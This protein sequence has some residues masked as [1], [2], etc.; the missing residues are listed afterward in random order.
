[1]PLVAVKSSVLSSQLSPLVDVAVLLVPVIAA[2]LFRSERQRGIPLREYDFPA[3]RAIQLPSSRSAAD[4]DSAHRSMRT[5][6]TTNTR[7]SLDTQQQCKAVA[8]PLCLC[9]WQ[10]ELH[11]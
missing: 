2:S 6:S 7:Q 8:Q 1:M 3:A 11:M 9:L 5:R 10:T 4:D